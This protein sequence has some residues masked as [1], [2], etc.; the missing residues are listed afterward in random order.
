MALN[1]RRSLNVPA[2]AW[3]TGGRL[4]G[5]LIGVALL[6]LVLDNSLARSW[7]FSFAVPAMSLVYSEILASLGFS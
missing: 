1:E 6:A 7:I 5:I 3:I 2:F 4:L